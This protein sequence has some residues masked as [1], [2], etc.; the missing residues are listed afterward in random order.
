MT[1]DHTEKK[2]KQ[3]SNPRSPNARHRSASELHP[4]ADRLSWREN[5]IAEVWKTRIPDA[6]VLRLTM[7]L[8]PD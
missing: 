3:E 6:I 4:Q 2:L 5:K 1:R 8:S 7:E